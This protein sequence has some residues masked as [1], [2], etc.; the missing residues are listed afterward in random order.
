MD[1]HDLH[2]I[3]GIP[4]DICASVDVSSR[5]KRPGCTC[6]AAVTCC[7]NPA[8][9]NKHNNR[10]MAEDSSIRPT[11]HEMQGISVD[12]CV[13]VEM[14]SRSKRPGCTCLAAVT[15]CTNPV[16]TAINTTTG[17]WQRTAASD[18]HDLHEMQGISDICVS[19]EM[20][21]VG[22]RDQ[23]VPAWLS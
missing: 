3:Q 16:H 10:Q 21:Q 1:L 19:V 22:Q 17:R 7:T 14:S 18:L 20:C 15:C 6:L 13:S 8:H 5:S 4:V 23:A 2:E 9:S 12:I 11:L